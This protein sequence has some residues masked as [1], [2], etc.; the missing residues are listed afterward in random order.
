MTIS[1]EELRTWLDASRDPL[2]AAQVEQWD[3]EKKASLNELLERMSESLWAEGTEKALATKALVDAVLGVACEGPDDLVELRNRGLDTGKSTGWASVSELFRVVPG[4][5]SIVTGYP[6]SG[7]SEF[8]DALTV[9][10]AEHHGWRFVI[11]S[12]EN[13]PAEHRAKLVEKHIGKPFRRYGPGTPVMSDE[14]VRAG[15]QWVRE[16]FTFLEVGGAEPP[17]LEEILSRTLLLSRSRQGLVIDPWNELESGRDR[18]EKE[19]DFVSRMLGMLKRFGREMGLHVWVVAHPA[20][21]YTQDGKPRLL[22]LMDISGSAHWANKADLGIVVHRPDL[23]AFETEIHVRKVRFKHVGKVGF[24]KLKWDKNT[25]RY[26]D[27]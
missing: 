24:C 8:V 17:L 25:G 19:T 3:W 26:S 1:N 9:N 13:P 14:E 12:M 2:A 5:L 7:K 11:A 18:D 6:N 15:A 21:V 10:L 20:K 22:G 16:R 4:Q 23:T 27:V